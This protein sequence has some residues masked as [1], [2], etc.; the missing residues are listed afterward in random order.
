MI[1]EIL[2]E[3]I[4]ERKM[5][6]NQIQDFF[7]TPLIKVLVW[8]RRV[9]K[10]SILKKIIQ[11]KNKDW[12]FWKNFFYINKEDL[13]FDN[14]KDYTDLQKEFLIFLEKI[15]KTKKIF[16]AIDEIQEI[17]WWEKF[18][19]SLLSKYKSNAEIFITGSNSG[20]LSSDLATLL[21]WRYI[22]FKINPLSFQEFLQ[23]SWEKKSK[24]MF[25]KYLE[26]G[27]MPWI[28]ETNFTQN[29]I[30]QYLK[31]VYNSILLKDI[32]KYFWVKNID[33]L[34]TLYKYILIN[35]WNVFS[36][37]KITDYLKA[38]KI[39]IS[40][41]TVLNYLNFWEKAFLIEKVKTQEIQSKK[42][43]EVYDKFY[44]EDLWI[45]N[46]IVWFELSRDIWLLLENYVFNTLKYYWYSVNIW[47]LKSYDKKTQKYKNLEIDFVAEK[48]GRK[49]YFQVCYLLSW[50]D[51]IEREFRSLEELKDSWPKYVL[52]LDEINF[53]ER[54][55]IKHLNIIELE[56]V[57]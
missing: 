48:D 20:L 37:K 5:Y 51:T 57:L 45:R 24:E 47:R 49:K 41:D 11:I 56:S 25:Y 15:D 32:V 13:L 12:N 38:Q 53:W 14:I 55:G 22:S 16:I 35:I 39:K 3:N 29:A 28:F 10:S 46:S 17:K 9:W 52:S 2:Q 8:S 33:F 34:E 19:N 23:F 54:N 6:L 4:I 1:E 7:W 40:V 27:W 36:A 31:W 26:Y 21:T 44:T 43:F 30:K 18:I 42:I 50:E